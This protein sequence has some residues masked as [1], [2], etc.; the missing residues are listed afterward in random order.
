[1]ARR[2]RASAP[3]SGGAR[4]GLRP[5]WPPRHLVLRGSADA[6]CRLF[7]TRLPFRAGSLPCPQTGHAPRGSLVCRA[8][9]G[10]ARN[11]LRHPGESEARRWVRCD[12]SAAAHGRGRGRTA[13]KASAG[14]QGEP[15]P[16][17]SLAERSGALTGRVLALA[18]SEAP[19]ERPLAR[20]FTPAL[21]GFQDA[22]PHRTPPARP[23]AAREPPGRPASQEVRPPQEPPGAG[24]PPRPREYF[25]SASGLSPDGRT[26]NASGGKQV[27]DV[28][29]LG[30]QR[31]GPGQTNRPGPD[32]GQKRVQNGYKTATAPKSRSFV[33]ST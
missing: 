27:K 23:G 2:A 4:G 20:A 33:T 13:E 21:S 28:D 6:S 32:S 14:G 16:T 18:R 1:M 29:P 10:S 31:P 7:G 19:L 17:I 26:K 9:R 22:E 25:S 30:A 5:L 15:R 11:R 8:R 3:R 24:W 12:G